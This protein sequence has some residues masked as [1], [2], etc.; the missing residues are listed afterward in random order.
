MDFKGKTTKE[1]LNIDI[2]DFNALSR[3]DLS[4]LVLR[5]G[6]TA[7]KRLNSFMKIDVETPATYQMNE[8][9]GLVTTKGKSLN[10]LRAEYVRTKN[11][12]M[13]ET[14]TR[15]G[16]NYFKKTTMD[17]LEMADINNISDKQFN[18]MWKA[19]EIIKKESPATYD[20]LYKYEIIEDIAKNVMKDGRVSA[21]NIAKKVTKRLTQIYED[22]K[23]RQYDDAGVSQ[24][25]D[26][27]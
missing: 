21:K 9:G 27:D 16:F 3:S 14:S 6:S 19:F 22:A 12:L 2:K 23:Q 1:L 26:F 15:K 8:S 10:Q 24:F 25:Y 5:L 17:R 20:K 18:K 4:K 11:F 13:A 7:N